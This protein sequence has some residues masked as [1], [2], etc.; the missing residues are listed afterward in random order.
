MPAA[1][2]AF[3]EALARKDF[4]QISALLDP[5]V[6]FRGLTPN[7]AWEASGASAVVDDVLRL[8]FEP[9]DHLERLVEVT[10]D[11]VA[12]RVRV[13]YRLEGHN[14]DGPF[15]VEQQVYY[16]TRDGRIAWMRALCSGFRPR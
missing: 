9:S 2:R 14:A 4:E 1:G 3:A 8:W 7:R 6:D 5:A 10:T 11:A 12:D 16:T 13:A 15:V